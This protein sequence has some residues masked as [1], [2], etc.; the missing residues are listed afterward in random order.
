MNDI[1]NNSYIIGIGTRNLVLNTLGRIY[2]KV[3]DRY[4]EFDFRKQ[5]GEEISIPNIIIVKNEQEVSNLTY[6]GDNKL[7]ISEDGKIWITQNKKIQ[8]IYFEIN[9]ESLTLNELTINGQITINTTYDD[10]LEEN[11][12]FIINTQKLIENL[13]AQFL[14]GIEAD[15]FAIK[16]NNEF[17]TG[18]WNFN[19][20]NVSNSITSSNN[21]M[22]IDFL[23]N[24]ITVCDLEVTCNAKLPSNVGSNQNELENYS[25]FKNRTY[26]GRE[27][28]FSEFNVIDVYYF[29]VLDFINYAYNIQYLDNYVNENSIDLDD[30]VNVFVSYNDEDEVELID[31]ENNK[32]IANEK[33]VEMGIVTKTIDDYSL[34]WT[35]LQE[36]NQTGY[37]GDIYELI[38]PNFEYIPFG[39]ILPGDVVILNVSG[40]AAKILSISDKNV[41]IKLKS[42]EDY[43]NDDKIIRILENGATYIQS[44]GEHTPYLEVTDKNNKTKVRIGTLTGIKEDGLDD[45]GI[46]MDHPHIRN[47]E[48]K[49]GI[50]S[51]TELHDSIIN[52]SNFKYNADNSGNIGDK[53]SW[54]S[55]GKVNIDFSSL[56]KKIE[57]ITIRNEVVNTNADIIYVTLNSYQDIPNEI[58]IKPYSLLY[59]KN[60]SPIDN[61]IRIYIGQDS[62]KTIGFT[63]LNKVKIFYA[64]EETWLELTSLII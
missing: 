42:E 56:E 6:P 64:M 50:I 5:F 2:I 16:N 32:S 36:V 60:V 55:D 10:N 8:P 52:N 43:I 49:D 20:F 41:I 17:I 47:I 11:P 9:Q 13:N 18:K 28:K 33:L 37:D 57:H 14:N 44:I 40:K 29:D 51:N 45:N 7:I 35:N 4:Y 30:W 12:P 23:N 53:I 26:F 34:L 22:V 27:F 38:I 19:S 63:S 31:I 61:D 21:N 62:R 59:I 1:I 58:H 46:W 39:T 54:T 25:G 48:L 3:K 15:Q 24:K